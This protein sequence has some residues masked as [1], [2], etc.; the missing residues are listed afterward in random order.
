MSNKEQRFTLGLLA[1]E[2]SILS[3]LIGPTDMFRIAQ[4]LAQVRDPGTN[5]RIETV[6]ISARGL[7]TV[8][9][10]GGLQLSGV[11]SPDVALDTC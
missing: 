4:K 2:D 7:N 8:T 1:L 5:L 3:C 11:Q 6:L 10:S 9:G